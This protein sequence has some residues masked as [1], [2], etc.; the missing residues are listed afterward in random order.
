M[1][2]APPPAHDDGYTVIEGTRPQDLLW[3]TAK[4]VG[5][6]AVALVAALWLDGLLTGL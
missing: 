4:L 6:M 3:S 5:S 1:K 2:K